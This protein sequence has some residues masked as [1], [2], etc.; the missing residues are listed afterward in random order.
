MS[1][2]E[3]ASLRQEVNDIS[4]LLSLVKEV[5]DIRKE[6]EAIRDEKDAIVS[7]STEKAAPAPVAEQP[8]AAEPVKA[9]EPVKEQPK[10]VVQEKPKE[11][12]KEEPKA[13][14]QQP[15][16]AASAPAQQ[17][18]KEQPK[19]QPKAQEQPKAAAAPAA[20]KPVQAAAPVAAGD[21]P[22]K[23]QTW[24]RGELLSTC[25]GD[26]YQLVRQ[27][28]SN[29][30]WVLLKHES[31]NQL[32]AE[33]VGTGGLS[34]ILPH[35]GEKDTAFA[36][37]RFETGDAESR[38]S[39]F[40]LISWCGPRAPIMRKAKMSVHKADV[41]D[42]FASSAVELQASDLDDIDEEAIRAS[43]RRAGGA[44]YNGQNS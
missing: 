24:N 23:S 34:E 11:Q 26:Y 12:P 33:A 32:R 30:N 4:R 15:K 10:P 7:K 13:Q 3:V 8:K 25:C 1:Q 22:P 5:V 41:K 16:P 35:F 19:E 29:V 39:K 18:A 37:V 40:V 44:N 14:P 6:V 2:A 21:Q 42:V 43:L 31:N 17:P 28:N 20:S 27:D 9:Q 38:R 36:Y